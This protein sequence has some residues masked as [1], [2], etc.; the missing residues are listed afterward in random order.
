M[1]RA[2]AAWQ[3]TG[4]VAGTDPLVV[5]LADGCLA[6]ALRPEVAGDD[7]TADAARAALLATGLA[8]VDTVLGPARLPC[9]E[10]YQAELYRMRG[11]LLL[12]RDGLAAA[13]EALACFQQ[14]LQLGRDQG[15]LA[16]E[17]RAAMSLVRL[18]ERQGD[19]YAAELT[20]ARRGLA[21]V[22]GR[23]TEGF[24]FPDLQDAA[25]LIG[26]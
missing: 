24:D 23:F 7:T 19:A 18:R 13:E 16:W 6:A 1:Q 2:M 26:G 5:V 9:G 17:L 15:A 4:M 21:A 12:A 20:E 22:Y 11:E 3:G 14:A 25:A 10:S 8:A